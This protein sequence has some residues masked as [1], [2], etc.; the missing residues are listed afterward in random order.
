MT[1]PTKRAAALLADFGLDVSPEA[2]AGTLGV[3]LV[4]ANA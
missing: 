3:V 2:E 1:R 4:V